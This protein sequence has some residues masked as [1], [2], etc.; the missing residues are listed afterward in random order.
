MLF[1]G[2]NYTFCV[3]IY[4][5]GEYL[6]FFGRDLGDFKVFI[7]GILSYGSTT[8]YG[9]F[10]IWF[11]PFVIGV[12]G[13]FYNDVLGNGYNYGQLE[14]GGGYFFIYGGL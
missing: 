12:W 3:T 10:I 13:G 6:M 7:Y 9:L 2:Y 4:F 1:T 5:F 14:Y 11:V 8:R